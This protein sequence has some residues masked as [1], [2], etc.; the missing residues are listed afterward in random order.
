MTDT[1]DNTNPAQKDVTVSYRTSDL[2]FS[3]YLCAIDIPMVST[4]TETTESGGRKVVFVF[5]IP[6]RSTM[7]KLKNSYF[8]GSG[9]V[10]V[11]R[12]VQALRSLKSM[13]HT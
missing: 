13:C 4:D 12:Y 10:K 1:L 11:Q 6:D 2:Y 5:R 9:T 3:S 8:G 7:E